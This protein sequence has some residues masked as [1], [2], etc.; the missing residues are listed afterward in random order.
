M[1]VTADEMQQF[2]NTLS[3]SE[4]ARLREMLDECASAWALP[5]KRLF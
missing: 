2:V 1:T 3:E 5:S 4:K